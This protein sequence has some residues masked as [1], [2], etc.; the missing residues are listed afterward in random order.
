[1]EL[2]EINSGIR[3][4][5]SLSPLLQHNNNDL[6]R[7]LHQFNYTARLFKMIM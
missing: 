4:E 6:Q 3:Q 5:E 2:I 7:L 1:M